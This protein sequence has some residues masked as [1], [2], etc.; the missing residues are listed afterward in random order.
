M[1]QQLYLAFPFRMD[2]GGALKRDRNYHIKEQIEQVLFTQPKER[3]FRPEFGVGIQRLIFEPNSATVQELARKR[4][5]VSISEA[6]QGEVDPR[7]LE[8]DIEA[9]GENLLIRISYVLA[10]IQ[11]RETLEFPLGENGG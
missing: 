8:I 6:L 11:Q 9:N 5:T 2:S 1:N 3:I 7:T 4:L 10:R